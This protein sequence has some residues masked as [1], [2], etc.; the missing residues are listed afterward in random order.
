[1]KGLLITLAVLISLGL[2]GWV[3]TLVS[4]QRF[5]DFAGSEEAV[6]NAPLPDDLPEPVSQFY[7][8]VY[9]EDI[10]ILESA[11]ISGRGTMRIQGITLPVR[12]RFS[13]QAG[14]NYRHYIETTWFGLPLLKVN[15]HY[16]DG[17]GRL[18]LPFGI[19]E[20]AKVDQ[21][22]NLGLWAE[23]I[24]M[25]SVWITDPR[26]RWEALDENTAIL[27]VPYKEDEQRLLVRFD[28]ETDLIQIMESM[29]FKGEE[30]ERK[31]LWLNEVRNW[32][33]FAGYRVPNSVAL[34]W[35]DEKTP[36]AEF[37]VDEVTY[38]QDLSG[39]IRA[40]GP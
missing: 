16:L 11:V 12:W 1:M 29:R 39:Y 26:V 2:I 21:G 7:A 17:A 18:E 23:T 24:W 9:G 40:K 3:G 28:P 27:I 20:G 35:F 8:K 6:D 30:S 15:E 38:N 31:T 14:E 13:H 19:S 22:A 25:P 37:T 34:V 36:W 33:S 10:P 32:G 4:P 5:P